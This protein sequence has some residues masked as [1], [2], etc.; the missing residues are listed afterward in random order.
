MNSV[1]KQH[2]FETSGID[3][4]KKINIPNH[5]LMRDLA[6]SNA[7]QITFFS[8]LTVLDNVTKLEKIY[9]L[10]Q[11]KY[12]RFNYQFIRNTLD[13]TCFENFSNHFTEKELLP[14]LIEDENVHP[15]Y[16]VLNLLITEN[17]SSSGNDTCYDYTSSLCKY[18]Q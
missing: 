16:L 10:I 7:F 9:S 17:I 3:K 11:R 1:N 14:F 12:I 18:I 15:K 2:P 8:E 5:W 4:V 6:Q 13:Q